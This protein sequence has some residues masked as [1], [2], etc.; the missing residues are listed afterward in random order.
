M[1]ACRNG[2]V[3][4]TSL[5]MQHRTRIDLK[6]QNGSTAR[7]AFGSLEGSMHIVE[8]LLE[9]GSDVDVATNDG[10]THLMTAGWY[11][12]LDVAKLLAKHKARIYL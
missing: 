5:L 11:G 9:N 4:V 10:W 8:L 6:T 1:T 12:H 2:H 7:L 3:D